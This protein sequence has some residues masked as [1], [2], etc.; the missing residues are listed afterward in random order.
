VEAIEVFP[1]KIKTQ[2][3]RINVTDCAA[4]VQSVTLIRAICG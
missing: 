1:Q 4:S 2:M 3:T